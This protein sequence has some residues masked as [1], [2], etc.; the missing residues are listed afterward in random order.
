MAKMKTKND[1]TRDNNM[2]NRPNQFDSKADVERQD[3]SESS[4]E[5]NY[6]AAGSRQVSG[7]SQNQQQSQPSRNPSGR[8]QSPVEK[9][10]QDFDP[11]QLLESA[12]N[13]IEG[14]PGRATLIGALVGGAV[15]GLF[16]TERGRSLAGAAYSYVRPMIADYARDFINSKSENAIDA[17]LPQ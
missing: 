14:H 16:A 3:D 8:K 17:A 7:S 4:E 1:F 11:A 15:A 10:L 5:T 2:S 9:T 6:Q 12:R 13:F